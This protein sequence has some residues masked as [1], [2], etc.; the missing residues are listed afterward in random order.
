[1]PWSGD[2][3]ER[4]ATVACW[5]QAFDRDMQRRAL[6][7]T[8]ISDYLSQVGK[9]FEAKLTVNG[10]EEYVFP[11]PYHLCS[12]AHIRRAQTSSLLFGDDDHAPS[13]NL[14]DAVHAF[15]RFYTVFGAPEALADARVSESLEASTAA[16]RDMAAV[17]RKVKKL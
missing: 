4:A 10:R 3:E 14:V 8:T 2:P 6:A 9:A 13:V 15:V 7:R 1:M 5:K 17:A 11:Q 16:Y 12:I